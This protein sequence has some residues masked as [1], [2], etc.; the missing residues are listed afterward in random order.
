MYCLFRSDVT[1]L[2][3]NLGVSPYEATNPA[4]DPSHKFGKKHE[5]TNI[6]FRDAK[7]FSKQHPP[8]ENLPTPKEIENI[9]LQDGYK[10][11]KFKVE[12]IISQRTFI[13]DDGRTVEFYKRK[14]GSKYDDIMIQT[15]YPFFIPDIRI[16]DFDEIELDIV[17]Y[18]E[19]TLL[20]KISK[21]STIAIGT[22]TKPYPYFRLPGWNKN[23]VGY[24][25][26]DGRKFWND[27]FGGRNYGPEWGKLGDVIGCGYKPKTGEV[28]FTKNG[29][30]LGIAFAGLRHIWYPTIGSDG[31]IKMKINFG[32]ES[33]VYK[34]AQGF[35]IGAPGKI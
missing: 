29:T 6:S 5:A 30:F 13:S 10:A 23:S 8:N 25:S 27:E 22:S 24:H 19:I 16:V 14:R 2:N 31:N 9:I 26:D 18:F 32:E 33:F 3:H 7:E 34:E 4:P 15:N 1:F 17:H 11:W 35:G 20:S 12:D 28:F 21:D